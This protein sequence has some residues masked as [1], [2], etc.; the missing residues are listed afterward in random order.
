MSNKGTNQATNHVYDSNGKVVK[1][2]RNYCM[3]LDHRKYNRNLV[4]KFHDN[5]YGINGGGSGAMRK[6]VDKELLHNMKSNRDPMAKI[7][8]IA[9]RSFG[10]LFFNYTSGM[11]WK[12]QLIKNIFS[13]KRANQ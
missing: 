6:I 4:C 7:T 3:I 9:V 1:L 10:W 11:P 2:H 8:Y 12:G 13:R 5:A